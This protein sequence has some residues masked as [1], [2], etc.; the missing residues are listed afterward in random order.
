MWEI[1]WVLLLEETYWR[2]GI[3]GI[4]MGEYQSGP[5]DAIVDSGTL[6]ITG[7]SQDIKAI[8]KHIEHHPCLPMLILCTF[9]VVI[10]EAIDNLPPSYSRLAQSRTG[11]THSQFI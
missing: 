2:V 11:L 3:D 1:H 4:K 6:L 5:T 9:S 8:A 10:F 7:L